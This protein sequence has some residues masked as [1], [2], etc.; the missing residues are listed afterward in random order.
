MSSIKMKKFG[1]IKGVFDNIRGSVNTPSPPGMNNSHGPAKLEQEVVEN[2]NPAMFTADQTVRHGFPFNPTAVAFDPVQK[3]LAMG[4]KT[5]RIRIFGRPGID[6]DIQHEK[7]VAII[8]IEFIIN[9]G[10]LLTL[11]TDNSVN[12]WDFRSEKSGSSSPKLEESIEF[13]REQLTAMHLEFLDK[14]LYIGTDKG[15]LHILNMETFS[16]S[17]YTASW[18]KFIDPMMKLSLIHI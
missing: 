10:K 6:L 16:L 7:E 4:T 3:L 11:C 17:G 8:Q 2:M 15:N 9:T 13:N 14:W 1:M 5:G 12:L 18:N